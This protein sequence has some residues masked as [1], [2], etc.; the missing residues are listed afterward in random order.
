MKREK[1]VKANRQ[2]KFV[3][4]LLREDVD[5]GSFP[6]PLIH[7]PGLSDTWYFHFISFSFSRS[8]SGAPEIGL[9]RYSRRSSPASLATTSGAI[10][11][12][13][14]C[15]ALG[16]SFVGLSATPHAS[17]LVHTRAEARR[18]PVA[19]RSYFCQ[20]QGWLGPTN[21]AP[22]RDRR[23]ADTTWGTAVD[24][25]FDT[26]RM[27]SVTLSTYD[28]GTHN[29]H[30]FL[31]Q[32]LERILYVWAIRHPASGY[33]QGINDLATPFFEVFLSAYLGKCWYLPATRTR[34]VVSDGQDTDADPEE[35]DPGILPAAVLAAVEADSFWCLSRLLD[36]IQDNYITAQPGIQR[37]VKRMAE[38]VARIDAPL[39]EHLATQGVE[40]MQFAFRWM[41]CLLMR[42]ISVKNTVRMWDTYLVRLFVFIFF[43]HL[44]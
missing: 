22:D 33:V 11:F 32:C 43:W 27:D 5:M 14:A 17:T 18:V 26:T 39:S 23:A 1:S 16:S 31:S 21:M 20:G 41:N 8:I 13:P 38:L 25:F 19:R 15:V 10:I 37:S 2:Y 34:P 44:E 7:R 3:E 40:F 36:G 24:A 35:I 29:A 30:L 6:R 12:H 28:A 9:V 4:C 42:E